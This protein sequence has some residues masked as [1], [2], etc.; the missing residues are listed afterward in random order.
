M[1]R[2]GK[3]LYGCMGK[4]E[5]TVSMVMIFITVMVTVLNV[6]ARYLFKSSI[7]WAQE[8]SGIAWTWTVMMGI[9][10]C[11]RRNM[12][13][14]VDFIVER[15]NE[16][17]RRWIAVISYV[18]LFVAFA[19]LTYMSVIITAKGFYKLTNYFHIPYSVKYVSAVIS[20]A[21]M[22]IYCVCYIYAAVTKPEEFLARVALDGNGLDELTP[23][24]EI[25]GMGENRS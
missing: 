11:F 18:I 2:I 13:M 17:L 8:V 25:E 21:F 20:F 16:K 14:G 10:W 15:L 19:F 6:F 5:E 9:S 22:S 7:P 12:H 1:K 3:F 4:V 23:E 24:E